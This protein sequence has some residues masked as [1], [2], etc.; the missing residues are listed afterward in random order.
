MQDCFKHI[1][2]DVELRGMASDPEIVRIKEELMT[3]L[4]RVLLASKYMMQEGAHGK[5]ITTKLTLEAL[6][7]FTSCRLTASQLHF[8]SNPKG[9]TCHIKVED[10]KQDL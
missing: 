9:I 10:L 5:H 4:K 6:V 3:T 1:L 8:T 2:A 7:Q